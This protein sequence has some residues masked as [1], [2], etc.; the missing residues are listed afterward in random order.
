[1]FIVAIPNLLG[2]YFLAPLIKGELT[3]Y[4]NTHLNSG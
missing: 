2:L 3:K 4:E 1:V